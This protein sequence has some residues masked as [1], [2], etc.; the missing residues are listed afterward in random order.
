MSDG[1]KQGFPYL[2]CSFIAINIMFGLASAINAA[3]TVRNTQDTINPVAC[4]QDTTDTS[5]L[6]L[7]SCFTLTNLTGI[8]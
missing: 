3:A 1:D 8:Q 2:Q 7:S 4:S 6:P 5:Q